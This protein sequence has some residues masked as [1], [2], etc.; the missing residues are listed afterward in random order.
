MSDP[1]KTAP[2]ALRLTLAVAAKEIRELSRDGRFRIALVAVAALLAVSLLLGRR[3]AHAAHTERQAA[4][5]AADEHFREQDAK[6]PHVAA[7]YGTYVFKPQ[8]ALTFVDPGIEPFVGVSVKLEAHKRNS[9][10]GARAKDGTALARFGRLSAASVLQLLVPLLIV[11]LGFAAWTGERERGTLRQIASLGVPSRILFAGKALGLGGALAALIGPAVLFGAAFVAVALS[12]GSSPSS[13]ARLACLAAAYAAYFA[14]YIAVTL[15]V[16]AVAPS[17]RFALVALLGF[18]VISGLVVPR[19]A[20]DAA[21]VLAKAPAPTEIAAAVRAS[22]ETGLPGGPAR[23][24]R[25]AAIAEQILEREGFKGAETLMDASLLEG[26]ELQA[27]ATFENEVIDH[28]FNRL[29]DA[30]ERQDRLVQWASI[31]SPLLA[32]RSLSMAFAGTDTAHHG[33]FADA[34]EA[35]RRALVDMLNRDFAEKAGAA[36]WSYKASRELWEK[37][38]PLV[39]EP[40]SAAWVLKN[41]AVSLTALMGWLLLGG[42]AAF[43]A[44]SRVR[45]IG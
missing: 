26:I 27:E 10:E 42:A 9:L 41:Q 24:E 6:N 7:H 3:Q 21:A 28:H 29:G 38:P 13:T 43:R 31:L 12:D 39:Y 40:P 25:V 20:S 8:G 37:A 2:S 23:E 22:L 32:V 18:W 17:S 44:A 14:A 45:V 4:Q 5:A 35:H 33:H 15:F 19:A 16:S 30:I 11:G 34:A 36:G 1:R